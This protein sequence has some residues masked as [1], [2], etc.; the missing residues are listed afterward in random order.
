VSRIT[1]LGVVAGTIIVCP[2]QAGTTQGMHR[3]LS[4]GNGTA[5]AL[6]A[7]VLVMS[8]LGACTS[9]YDEAV[10][11]FNAGRN[12]GGGGGG[13]G[14]GGGGGGTPPPTGNF[15]PNFSE[16]QANVFT[17]DCATSGCHA[18]GA[19][20]A[21]LNLEAANS[22]M[23]LVGVASLQ[24]GGIE[25]V[26]PGDPDNSYLVQ[27]LEG[28][29]GSGQQMPLGA[30]LEQVDIDTIRQWISDGAIDDRV[31]SADPVRVTTLS[32][33]PGSTLDA[34]PSSITAGF[35]REL[36]ATTVN[37]STF[38][39]EASTNGTFDDGD[40]V[41]ITAGSITVPGANPQSAVFNL[42]AGLADDTYRV[43]LLGDG[44]SVIEDLDANA[45]DG[46]YSGSF[47]SG[48]GTAGGDFVVQF[49]ITTPVAIGPTLDE[50]QAAVFTPTCATSTCHSNSA[51]AAG[52]SLADADTS[53]AEMVGQFSNQTGQMN[54][55][56]VAE[57]DP[58]AS[59][60]IRKLEGAAGITGNRM[61][62]GGALLQSDIDVIRQW[63]SDGAAR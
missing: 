32:V 51:Q 59:Y 26:A 25:R 57:G 61:P 6:F 41:T 60:L 28:T 10:D 55:L 58:D 42:A 47:P 2:Q 53:Y 1:I 29:A 9:S 34:S 3:L 16:L 43:R 50:I 48:D 54:V 62:P 49:T 7:L 56:L 40:D 46:E 13:S 14:G 44:A 11:R 22:Y 31:P 17:P 30:P 27:K 52:L 63:I 24:D 33:A 23:M 12:P 19:P 5:S 38:I 15:G 39:L 45:L 18:G 8:S 36:N 37:A 21:S 20:A 35:D 4:S